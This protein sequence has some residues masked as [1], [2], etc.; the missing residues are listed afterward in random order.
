[1]MGSYLAPLPAPLIEGPSEVVLD[2]LQAR[3]WGSRPEF[4]G[5]G[6]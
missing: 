4:E 1:M 6:P 5:S 3:V 2:K